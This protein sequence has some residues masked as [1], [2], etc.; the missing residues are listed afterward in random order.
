MFRA[1][2]ASLA[3][4]VLVALLPC[5][6]ATAQNRIAVSG[7]S[8]WSTVHTDLAPLAD[9]TSLQAVDF[10]V[11]YRHRMG[12]AWE[13]CA[14]LQSGHRGFAV[15]VPFVE[16][17]YGA[18]QNHDFQLEFTYLTV[19]VMI[20]AS[21]GGKVIASIAT[22]F[23]P[24]YAAQIYGNTPLFASNGTGFSFS[25]ERPLVERDIKRW[26]LEVLVGCGLELNVYDRWGLEL[27]ARYAHGLV[28]LNDNDYT[29]TYHC[30]N[31]AI[32]AL[33]GLTYRLHPN[34]DPATAR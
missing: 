15:Y 26:D 20:R 10:G 14:G 12:G 19:P 24:G 5:S 8:T 23:A 31:R 34:T 11:D 4:H 33:L 27:S 16:P 2:Q 9:R 7:I 13:L 30:R 18:E 22:G 1:P 32:Q 3:I 28:S 6:T 21:T 17:L 29:G 25:G